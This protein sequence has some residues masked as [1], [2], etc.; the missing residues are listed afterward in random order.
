MLAVVH[1]RDGPRGCKARR[2][3]GM[4]SV[5][6]DLRRELLHPRGKYLHGALRAELHHHGVVALCP[7]IGSVILGAVLVFSLK[8]DHC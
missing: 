6:R 1:G 7:V 4:L 2:P 8:P 3:T 5:V